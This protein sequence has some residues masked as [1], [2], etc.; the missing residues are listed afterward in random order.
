[1]AESSSFGQKA[2]DRRLPIWQAVNL[3]TAWWKRCK[4]SRVSL[5]ISHGGDST[6]WMPRLR[7]VGGRE[8]RLEN[9]VNRATK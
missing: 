5:L 4:L 9:E 1:M 3:I 7:R 6:V 8:L 2:V